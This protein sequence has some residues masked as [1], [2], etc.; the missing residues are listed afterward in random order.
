MIKVEQIATTNESESTIEALVYL[1]KHQ[2]ELIDKIDTDLEE[3]KKENLK[4]DS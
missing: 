2:N 3:N 1:V 4:L